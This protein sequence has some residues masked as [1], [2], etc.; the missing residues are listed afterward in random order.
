MARQGAN[1]R[2]AL[3]P[4]LRAFAQSEFQGITLAAERPV[5]C[6]EMASGLFRFAAL[7]ARA[8][9]RPCGGAAVDRKVAGRSNCIQRARCPF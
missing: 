9:G 5:F 6:V 3:T 8:T 7:R 4:A 1:R 2:G